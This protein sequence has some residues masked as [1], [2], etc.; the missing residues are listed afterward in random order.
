M[1]VIV[2]CCHM[3][4]GWRMREGR[5]KKKRRRDVKQ[6]DSSPCVIFSFNLR[7]LLFLLFLVN[8]FSSFPITAQHSTSLGRGELCLF[9]L[10]N[11]WVCTST[12]HLF[13][14]L[15]SG[16]IHPQTDRQRFFFSFFS[17]F[18]ERKKLRYYFLRYEGVKK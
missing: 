17:F 8:N 3:V 1:C 2:I 15:S 10:L 14:P 4:V 9:L 7:H 11:D 5:K 12:N 13:V 6:T 16:A 18:C